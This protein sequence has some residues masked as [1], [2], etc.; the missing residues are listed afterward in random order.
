MKNVIDTGN[1]GWV[2]INELT[3]RAIKEN[4]FPEAQQKGIEAYVKARIRVMARH[5]KSGSELPELASIEIVDNETREAKRVYKQLALFTVNDYRQAIVY[6]RNQVK[7]HTNM[8]KAFADDCY[9]KFGVQ[10]HFE[11]E[12]MENITPAEENQVSLQ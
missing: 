2:D 7:H 12:T 11:F 6:H 10:L 9:E 4:W 3:I 8:A 1:L 5:K